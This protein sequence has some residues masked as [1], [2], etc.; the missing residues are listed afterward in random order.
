LTLNHEHA[1]ENLAAKSQRVVAQLAI[2]GIIG[3]LGVDALGDGFEVV[4]EDWFVRGA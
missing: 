1:L 3:E 2:L 4:R